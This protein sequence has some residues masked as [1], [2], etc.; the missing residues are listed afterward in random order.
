MYARDCNCTHASTHK[1]SLPLRKVQMLVCRPRHS[2]NKSAHE[3]M[4][5]RDMTEID[6]RSI[7]EPLLYIKLAPCVITSWWSQKDGLHS[8]WQCRWKAK[9]IRWLSNHREPLGAQQQRSA[10]EVGRC[11]IGIQMISR[12]CQCF[13]H[14]APMVCMCG[15]CQRRARAIGSPAAYLHRLK[16][17]GAGFLLCPWR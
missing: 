4:G 6:R 9:S 2:S 15:M 13:V 17:R 16:L 10:S 7:Y 1:R 8:R 3:Y 5:G 12:S 14:G 11:H